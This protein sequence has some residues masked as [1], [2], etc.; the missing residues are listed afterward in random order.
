MSNFQK[1]KKLH[2]PTLHLLLL[3]CSSVSGSMS[4]SSYL[5]A[6]FYQSVS[7]PVL[8]VAIFYQSASLP[9]LLLLAAS[10]V[11]ADVAGDFC[12]FADIPESLSNC[13]DGGRI[14]F[15]GR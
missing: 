9:V 2:F 15:R 4:D 11:T 14:K 13:Q 3:A 10:S 6:E 1:K 7:L 8:L 5:V 12:Q